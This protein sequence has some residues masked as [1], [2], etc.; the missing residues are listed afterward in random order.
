MKT[1]LIFKRQVTSDGI[2]KT[3]T[4]IV[5]V[6]VPHI[7]TGEGWV[8]SGHTDMLE[9]CENVYVHCLDQEVLPVS[10]VCTIKIEEPPMITTV[11]NNVPAKFESSVKGTAR[12]IRAKGK[13]RITYR[14]N[15]TTSPNSVCISDVTKQ[16][17][18]NDC[19]RRYG[20][21]TSMYQFDVDQD[22]NEYDFWNSFIDKEYQRQKLLLKN[23]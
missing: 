2:L 18:F 12:L 15:N 23:N 4:R 20:K 7:N 11:A 6:D 21:A 16:E 14:K 22:R 8:L 10:A 19:K 5:P 13:I 3:V 1:N 9:T 17:F